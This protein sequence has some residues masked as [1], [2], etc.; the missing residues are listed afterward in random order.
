QV[1]ELGSTVYNCSCLAQDLEKI[2][3]A[4]WTLGIP[5][6]TIPFPWPDKFST[7]YNK[8]TP[9]EMTVNNTRTLLYLSSSP[10][11]L[12]AKGRTEDID[13]ILS[14]IDNAKRFIYISVMDYTPTEEFSEPKRY[15]PEI[16]NHL[17]KAVYER[18]VSVRLLISCW[19]NSKPPM[20]PFLSSLA[21][22]NSSKPHYNV[23]VKIFV[24]PV[25]PEQKHI[26]FSR[27]NHNKYMVTDEVAYI[28]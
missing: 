2:F 6:A 5:N 18:H 21:A 17:R 9:M 8:D 10:P 7:I 27:V 24:V 25:S 22:L 23:E 15:W 20:F 12:S 16:D 28:G 3:D 1:K 4:Y 26:P 13:A 14:V 11:P 19:A